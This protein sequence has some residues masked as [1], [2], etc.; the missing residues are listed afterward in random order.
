MDREDWNRRYVGSE[1]R[2]TARPNRF[3][4]GEV[5]DLTPGRALDLAC[6]EGR[7]AIWLAEHGWQVTGVDFSDVALAKAS[8]LARNRQ[9]NPTWVQAD[10]LDYH[11]P[12]AA[13]EL[14]IVFYMQVPAGDRRTILQ[15]AARAVAV[16][17]TLLL[18]GHDS[19]NLE[20]GYG[21]PQDPAVLYSAAD[22]VD[23]LAGTGLKITH[24]ERVERSVETADG[25]QTALDVLLRARR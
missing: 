2:W 1:L 5:A 7:N 14:V 15:R 4:V 20:H 6:G 22:L 18:V 24:A 25:E 21:G 12:A 23:D 19:R 10:L 3:L 16:G 17:G 9:V 11:P 13:F 8:Q